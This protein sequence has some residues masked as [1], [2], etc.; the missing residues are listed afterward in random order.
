MFFY[1]TDN[2]ADIVGEF[3]DIGVERFFYDGN[4]YFF[5]SETDLGIR[6]GLTEIN[7]DDFEAAFERVSIV[8]PEPQVS[9]MDRLLANTDYIVMMMEG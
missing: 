9:D 8:E 6:D 5:E 1:K 3:A 4:E 7:Q 2:L